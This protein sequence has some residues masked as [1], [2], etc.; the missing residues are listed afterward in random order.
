MAYIVLGYENSEKN[1]RKKMNRTTVATTD[2]SSQH[3]R[4]RML[5]LKGTMVAIGGSK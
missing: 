2:P 5:V 1:N 3:M 4:V